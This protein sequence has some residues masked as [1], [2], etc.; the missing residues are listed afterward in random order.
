MRSRRTHSNLPMF[1]KKGELRSFLEMSFTDS[2]KQLIRV[3]VNIMI[4]EEMDTFRKE[5]TD[6]VFHFN[7]TYGRT[8]VG[9]F[10]EVRDIP[11]PRFRDNPTGFEPTTLSVFGEQ[12][13]KFAH[14]IAEMHRLGISQR[15]V[16][17][18]AKTCLGVNVS[19]DRVG[20]IHKELAQR[21]E[22]QINSTA[23]TDEFTHLLLDGLWTKTKG[24]GFDDNDAVLLCALGVK[25]NGERQIIGFAVARQ[26]DYESWHDLLLS[27]KQ[28]GLAGKNL[29][30][31][32]TDDAEGLIGALKQLY[33][34]VKRQ[35]CLV[36]KMRNV[37]GKTSHKNKAGVAEQ[38]K[39]VYQ[40]KTKESALLAVKS[41]CKRW[42]LEE[43]K[44]ANSLKHHF[45]ETLTYFDFPEDSWKQIRTNNI[46]EREFR[47]LRRRIKVFDSSFNDTNSMGRYANSIIN[48]LNENYP[49]ARKSLHTNP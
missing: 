20:A 32:I 39:A 5:M 23:L 7:G 19:K 9:P 44:A 2:L 41:F 40:E 17:L 46:L 16:K 14:L 8:M 31:A 25:A 48:Y 11:I 43:P 49:A 6:L 1:T 15:K 12:Q 10:G 47:E 29:T 33:P 13:E 36:H 27:I 4:K 38:L 24:Y 21:E 3:T 22:T 35:L 28:R 18:L 34:T 45:L 26:E 37:I 30:L 42:Y